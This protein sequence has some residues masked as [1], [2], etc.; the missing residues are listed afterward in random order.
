MSYSFKDSIHQ[1]SILWHQPFTESTTYISSKQEAFKITAHGS[2]N[3]EVTRQWTRSCDENFPPIPIKSSN[4][5]RDRIFSLAQE[6]EDSKFPYNHIAA[7]SIVLQPHL[8]SREMVYY[9][10][11]CKMNVVRSP[12]WPSF[13]RE[14]EITFV[15]KKFLPRLFGFVNPSPYFASNKYGPEYN[16]QNLPPYVKKVVIQEKS[17]ILESISALKSDDLKKR[18]E[19]IVSE[20]LQDKKAKG[21]CLTLTEPN[22]P[23]GRV[24]RI[25]FE[26]SCNLKKRLRV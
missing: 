18:V 26:R 6:S 4:I 11:R 12:V 23:Q 3:N 5:H 22:E 16:P 15:Q 25:Y 13:Q 7:L 8:K 20:F 21:I 9:Q 17:Q 2:K 14:S 24:H 1:R 19:K 10:Y